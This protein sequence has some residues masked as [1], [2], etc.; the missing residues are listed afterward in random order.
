MT[1]M[2]LNSAGIKFCRFYPSQNLGTS[3]EINFKNGRLSDFLHIS[4][5]VNFQIIF[6][7][8][9]RTPT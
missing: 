8:K 7:L 1:L 4:Q 5:M 2:G 9:E 3:R 6:Q